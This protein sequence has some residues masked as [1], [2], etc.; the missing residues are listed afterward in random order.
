MVN[1]IPL[2]EIVIKKIAKETIAFDKNVRKYCLCK[3]TS[4][5]IGCPNY[6]KKYS[7]PPNSPYLEDFILNGDFIEFYLVIGILDFKKYKEIRLS[8]LKERNKNDINKKFHKYSDRE[9]GNLLYWQNQMK[10]H[11]FSKI[12]EIEETNPNFYLLVCGSGYTS[13]NKNDSLG[14][15]SMES[16]GIHVFDTFKN[17]NMEIE[18]NPV[19]YVRLVNLLCYKEKQI[20]KKKKIIKQKLII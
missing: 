13:K 4:H 3:Y 18:R 9:L 5:K 19:N 11:I 17:N 6:N 7:C 10:N 8:I 14:L 15:Y 12:N 2:T 1:T 16:V 20:I